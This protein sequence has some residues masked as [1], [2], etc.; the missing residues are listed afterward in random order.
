MSLRRAFLALTLSLL[1]GL[2]HGA[3]T[4]AGLPSRKVFAIAVQA[5][6]RIWL[7]TEH[8][9][10]LWDGRQFTHY[11]TADGLPHDDVTSIALSR[12]RK[13]V[14]FGTFGGVATWLDTP[15][16]DGKRFRAYTQKNSGLVNDVVYGLALAGDRGEQVWIATTNGAS[17]FDTVADRWSTYDDRNAPFHEV[18]CYDVKVD[19]RDTVWY[20]VWGSGILRFRGGAWTDYTDPDGIFDVDVLRNDGNLHEIVT[21]VAVAD[22]VVW[23]GAYFGLS[24]YDGTRWWNWTVKDD[25]CGLPSD[26]INTV[27]ARGQTVWLGTD[28]GL[29]SF[30]WTTKRWTTYARKANG[31]GEVRIFEN[32][33]WTTRET[34]E[35][36]PDNFVW[37]IAFQGDRIWVGTSAGVGVGRFE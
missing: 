27:A 21:G 15:T 5:D 14:W 6:D 16:P 31:K 20:G 10:A 36:I 3:V 18:W 35:A 22:G 7:G 17:H 29:C 4:S 28:K 13:R 8:G 34:D 12:D 37:S 9:L 32:G 33:T 2:V 1:P 24:R 26:F 19:E 30:N 25:D 11:F 23:A